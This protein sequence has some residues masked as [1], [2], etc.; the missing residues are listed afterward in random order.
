MTFVRLDSPA[1]STSAQAQLSSVPAQTGPILLAA[2]Q[3]ARRRLT[4]NVADTVTPTASAPQLIAIGR[5][6]PRA[7]IEAWTQTA[8]GLSRDFVPAAERAAP[9]GREIKNLQGVSLA[10]THRLGAIYRLRDHQGAGRRVPDDPTDDPVEHQVVRAEIGAG[11]AELGVMGFQQA[12]GKLSAAGQASEAVGTMFGMLPKI[13]AF[14]TRSRLMGETR[15]AL[16]AEATLKAKIIEQAATLDRLLDPHPLIREDPPAADQRPDFEALRQRLAGRSDMIAADL[17][18]SLKSTVDLLEKLYDGQDLS[19]AHLQDALK[20]IGRDRFATGVAI[21]GGVLETGGAIAATVAEIGEHTIP[22]LVGNIGFGAG[23]LGGV[24]TLPFSAKFLADNAR[25]IKP[26]AEA[27]RRGR[28]MLTE[29]AAAKAET[30]RPASRPGALRRALAKLAIHRSETRS[31]IFKTSLFGTAAAGSLTGIASYGAAALGATVVAGTLATVGMWIGIAALTGF[32]L[33]SVGRYFYDRKQAGAYRTDTLKKVI[34]GE[35]NPLSGPIKTR[36][37]D[38]LLNRAF[39]ASCEQFAHAAI[40][41]VTTR[42]RPAVPPKFDVSMAEPLRNHARMLLDP[43]VYASGESRG[44]VDDH[45][46]RMIQGLKSSLNL[47]DQGRILGPAGA[48]ETAAWADGGDDLGQVLKDAL[49]RALA[50]SLRDWNQARVVLV[51][52][53]AQF[54]S[55]FDRV[56]IDGLYRENTITAA[57]RQAVA[58]ALSAFMPDEAPL[59]TW[60]GV[61]PEALAGPDPSTRGLKDL[62][63]EQSVDLARAAALRKLLRRD[64]EALL[65]TY[66]Q[67][68]REARLAGDDAS[69]EQLSGDLRAFGAGDETLAAVIKASD[70]IQVFHAAGRLA[71]ELNFMR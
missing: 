9:G 3:P 11:G 13:I 7:D 40:D 54:S 24:I 70:D 66:A 61:E 59:A 30:L 42:P 16:E 41:R 71:K 15:E 62:V 22:H 37:T 29:T 55:A 14:R 8:R 47:D 58:A 34:T 19:E 53:R 51:Q 63:D 52:N 2:N 35:P 44:L 4:Q 56:E 45:V 32:T 25:S 23:A 50:G 49:S 57:N 38:K 33:Y 69:I 28:E 18:A 20:E 17:H 60:G 43:G 46:E 36:Q 67:S 26:H 31:R 5:P 48:P 27:A 65:L 21:A 64:P 12:V 6:Q 68:L 10:D 39:V 1:A